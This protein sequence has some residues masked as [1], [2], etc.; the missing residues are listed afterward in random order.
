MASRQKQS[1]PVSQVLI[2]ARPMIRKWLGGGL[3]S[4]DCKLGKVEFFVPET[5]LLVPAGGTRDRKPYNPTVH[6]ET[7][8]EER[9]GGS[10]CTRHHDSQW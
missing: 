8:D 10:S 2:R 5:T 3:S 9:R 6:T 4:P 1:G 7:A